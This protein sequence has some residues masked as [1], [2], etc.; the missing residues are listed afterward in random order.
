MPKVLIK[1]GTRSQLNTAQSASGLNAGELYLITDESKVAVGTAVNAYTEVQKQDGDLDAIAALSGTSG[2]L[3]KT[4]ANTWALDTN[5]YLTS[6]VTSVTGTA[7]IVSS[8]GATPAISIS[9]A[10]TL[11]AGSMSSTD[12]TKLDGIASGATANTGTVTSVGITVPT[13]LSVTGTPVTSSG[14]F[15]VTFAAGYSIPTTTSQTNWDTAYTDRL[16]WDGGSTGLVAATA[17]TSLGLVIGTN[18][19]AYDADLTTWAGKTAPSG[20]VVGT[21]DTQTLTNKTLTSPTVSGGT[22]DG[23]IIGDTTPAAGYFTTV[24]EKLTASRTYYVATTGSDS[25]AGLSAGAPFLTIQKAINTS[26]ALD[27]GNYNITIS[28]ADGTY[29]ADNTL[30][31]YVAGSGIITIQ[32]NTTTPANVVV[33]ASSSACFYGVSCGYWAIK[34]FKLTATNARG[35]WAQGR[36]TLIR[37]YNMN[38]GACT[39]EHMWALQGALIDNLTNWTISGGASSH[40]NSSGQGYISAGSLTVTLSGTPAFSNAFASADMGGVIIMQYVTFTGSATGKRYNVTLNAVVNTAG[41]GA[42]YLPGNVSGTTATGG[43]YA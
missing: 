7:P 22:V 14:T 29:S 24:R 17:R 20:T 43:Q 19:Q 36:T 13:G 34:G 10:T 6:A 2:F 9:A 15:A 40:A 27:L 1:R 37:L 11:A 28:V 30:Y 33:N 35:I 16:K 4:A 31:P 23:A 32:G 39:Y 3:K 42:T 25:N 26:V 21:S 18:V 5:T 41:G 12:K 38:F 8:G